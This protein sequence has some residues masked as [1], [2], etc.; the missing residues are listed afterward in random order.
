M[1]CVTLVLDVYKNELNR[2]ILI[3]Q[4]KDFTV[5]NFNLALNT[6]FIDFCKPIEREPK[7]Y[8]IVMMKSMG[9]FNHV[10]ILAFVKTRL[11]VLHSFAGARHTV[12]TEWSKLTMYNLRPEGLYECL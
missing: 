8:D 9:H 5:D 11:F 3:P 7:D 4:L 10:G 1:N 6:H 2:E 12:L